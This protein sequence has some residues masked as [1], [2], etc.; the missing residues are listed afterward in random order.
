MIHFSFGY[1]LDQILRTPATHLSTRTSG[2]GQG[3]W[4]RE[5]L[6]CQ[7]SGEPDTPAPSLSTP[8]LPHVFSFFLGSSSL[9]YDHT[10]HHSP[11]DI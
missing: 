11:N 1:I 3:A 6:P 8:F 9:P 5:D 7:F 10:S 2:W 4:G